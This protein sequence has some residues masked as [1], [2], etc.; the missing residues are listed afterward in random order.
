MSFGRGDTVSSRARF[1]WAASAVA[2]IVVVLAATVGTSRR[3]VS[4]RRA[5]CIGNLYQVGLI[6]RRYAQEHGGRYP[7]KW[8]SIADSMD[9][10]DLRLFLA[11]WNHSSPG[12]RAAVDS[13]AHYALIPGRLASDP[14]DAILA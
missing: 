11:P 7:S 2:V 3:T 9:E 6:L 14:S 4:N 5:A 1:L 8:I 13:W 12:E 10:S